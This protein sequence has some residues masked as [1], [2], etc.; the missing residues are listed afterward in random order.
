MLSAAY[1]QHKFLSDINY[2]LSH[3]KQIKMKNQF[4]KLVAVSGMFLAIN[5]QATA[6]WSL[7]G[8]AGTTPPTTFIGT[9]DLQNFV[10]KTNNASRI[11]VTSTGKVG[12]GTNV[13]SYAVDVKDTGVTSFRVQSTVSGSSN[14]I[15]ARALSTTNCLVNYKTGATQ[16]WNTG[17]S[18]NDDFSIIDA[19]NQKRLVISQATGNVGIGTSS[20]S[21]SLEVAA[22]TPA[23]TLLRT[24]STVDRSTVLEL[25][26]NNASVTGW[27]LAVGGTG[28]GLGLVNGEYYFTSN[29]K[30]FLVRNQS[31]TTETFRILGSNGN[32]GIGNATP[33]AKLDVKG[34]A[35]IRVSSTVAS[36]GA[37]DWIAGSFGG[38]DSDRV[39]MGNLFGCATIGAHNK[40]HT[41]WAN[42]A[43]NQDGGSVAIGTKKFAA[44]YLLS[45][46]GAVMCTALRVQ[47]FAS[48]PD[49]VFAKN[50][51]LKSLSEVEDYITTNKR[52]PGMP[53]DCEVL[54]NG[55]DVG[56]MQA[57]VVEKVEENTLYIIQLSKEN[58]ELKA[59][60]KAIQAQLNAMQK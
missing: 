39:V 34:T 58:Q 15:L 13:P 54:E 31:G 50:Y 11:T 57:K 2:K 22:S 23:A 40:N 48:W 60:L 37:L 28:N 24:I 47:D 33:I 36:N 16:V 6:Q 19:S 17:C 59:Q 38:N 43:I 1:L 14:C 44:G 21:Y 46:N 29:G 41:A 27:Q 52:L 9:T 56:Q 20:P 55:I 53:S 3:L 26:N 32:V 10:V 18:A 4:L 51:D 42:L 12:I 25:R 5:H 30:D 35:G 8:N 49:Y 7:T 45:V